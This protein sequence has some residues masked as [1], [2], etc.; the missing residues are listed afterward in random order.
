MADTPI[1][2]HPSRRR[3]SRQVL[4][5]VA[6]VATLALAGLTACDDE[7]EPPQRTVKGLRDAS[8]ISQRE[9]LRIGINDDFPLMSYL[10]GNVRKGFDVE[11][12]RYIASSLGFQ[13]DLSIQWVPVRT[14]DRIAKLRSGEVDIV[15]ASFSI[16][17]DREQLVGFA[18]PYLITS[19]EALVATEYADEIKSLPDLRKEEHVV[20][21]A[22]GSTTEQLL[23]ERGIPRVEADSPTDCRDGILRGDYHAMVSDKTILA[24]FRSQNP[25]QLTLVDMPFGVEEALGIGVPPED[26][27]LRDLVSYFLNKSYLQGQQGET[28]VWQ[29][30]YTNTLGPWLGSA[31]QPP[32]LQAP[33]LVDHDDKVQR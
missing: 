16:T 18:G 23:I 31:E 20:C 4:T 27:N 19:P 2:V 29:T 24:G 9:K 7:S 25:D 6:V 1:P 13:G 3:R 26:E 17:P 15:V 33:D 12:A 21:V 14:E 22:G 10:E 11:I 28:T 8:T 32:P 30:A 5:T